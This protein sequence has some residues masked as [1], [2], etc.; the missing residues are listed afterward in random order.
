MSASNNRVFGYMLSLMVGTALAA[1]PYHAAFAQ[2]VKQEGSIPVELVAELDPP[3]ISSAQQEALAKAADTGMLQTQLVEKERELAEMRRT[4]DLQRKQIEN[5]ELYR[6]AQDRHGFKNL[7]IAHLDYELMKKQEDLERQ[8]R[9]LSRQ[10]EWLEKERL[11]IITLQRQMENQDGSGQAA[12]ARELAESRQKI[13]SIEEKYRSEM[14][15]LRR[16]NAEMQRRLADAEQARREAAAAAPAVATS[17]NDSAA[18]EEARLRAERKMQAIERRHENERQQLMAD[19][20]RMQQELAALQLELA[21]K[22]I[23]EK[24]AAVTDQERRDAE[25]RL[26]D[27]EA[28]AEAERRKLTE[29]NARLQQQMQALEEARREAAAVAGK[30]VATAEERHEAE[31]RLAELEDQ[32]MKER[33][34]LLA[35]NL[36]L[37]DYLVSLQKEKDS[38][39]ARLREEMQ[40]ETEARTA[41]LRR[42]H[43]EEQERQARENEEMQQ[44]LAALQKAQQAEAERARAAA[45][46]VD[47]LAIAEAKLSEL[48]KNHE[49]ERLRLIEENRRMQESLAELQKTQREAAQNSLRE[50]SAALKAAQAE[51]DAL[52]E[53]NREMQARMKKM[54]AEAARKA[55]IETA[56]GGG[57]DNK[58]SSSGMVWVAPQQK[59]QQEQQ[60][61]PVVIRRE[62]PQ[63]QSQSQ[64]RSTAESSRPALVYK[65]ISAEDLAA[66]QRSHGAQPVQQKQQP[67]AT[68]LQGG[69]WVTVEPAAPAAQPV[70]VQPTRGMMPE[71]QV[72]DPVYAPQQN[73]P[74]ATAAW[75]PPQQAAPRQQPEVA[76]YIPYDPPPQYT[77]QEQQNHIGDL[78]PAVTV[79]TG[80]VIPSYG[81]A[82]AETPVYDAPP[83]AAEEA[84]DPY[85]NFLDDV[86]SVH[87]GERPAGVLDTPEPSR[88]IAER[89]RVREEA[90]RAAA[91]AAQ[92]EFLRRQQ[93]DM[94][95]QMQA[96][97][98]YDVQHMPQQQ[99]QGQIPRPR[100]HDLTATTAAVPERRTVIQE[101]KL[102]DRTPQL[103]QSRTSDAPVALSGLLQSA[104][105]STEN[106]SIN[107]DGTMLKWLSG[108]FANGL[109]ERQDWPQHTADIQILA[110]EYV[111]RYNRDC[112]NNLQV[113]HDDRNTRNIMTVHALC[114]MDGNRYEAVFVFH[115][116]RGQEFSAF[117]HVAQP[118]YGSRLRSMAQRLAGELQKQATA[119]IRIDHVPAQAS[120]AADMLIIE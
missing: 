118:E 43:M 21:D 74:T 44:R 45:V 69:E 107:R 33:R 14:Q 112:R 67:S 16:E 100:Y 104:G 111:A 86:M 64:S 105:I 103:L 23:R 61:D 60:H 27:I 2:S 84:A 73:I 62:S 12:A 65:E 39:M 88:V 91:D 15:K 55:A 70:A 38:E 117:V 68:A 85:R 72:H 49:A 3:P 52:L 7:N 36:Q 77:A 25:K 53:Q 79:H 9:D 54:E 50:D 11:R 93:Q 10:Q 119:G 22:A 41:E 19:H 109:M 46:T 13:S 76:S 18:A 80:P 115:G 57:M 24:D 47:E 90:A 110:A 66:L 82:Y 83:P 92:Q 37:Q 89:Q 58:I 35:N 75:V 20:Q 97:T 8:A 96:Q 56:A 108:G 87:R 116:V 81:T 59:Q 30:A 94:L 34:L 63:R 29:E 48:Q 4:L 78:Q 31:R 101:Q 28:R 51:R 99:Q 40:R 32:Y 1:A 114:P 6:Q 102:D 17:A 95:R 71:L 120:S 113:L 5:A 106:L 98:Q 26:R 42:R